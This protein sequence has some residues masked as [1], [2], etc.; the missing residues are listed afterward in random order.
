MTTW[1]LAAMLGMVIV[2]CLAGSALSRKQAA[3][4]CGFLLVCSVLMILLVPSQ[5]SAS[6]FLAGYETLYLD[7]LSLWL[8]PYT[9]LIYLAIFLCAPRAQISPS[10]TS[11]MML[12]LAAD[13]CCFSTRQPF[14][15]ALFWTLS[16]LGLLAE[17]RQS[18]RQNQRLWRILVTYLG[19]S[20]LLFCLGVWADGAQQP[21][22]LVAITLSI[23]MRKAMIP[24]HHWLPE[25]FAK[26][27]LGHVIALC[28]PQVG[29]YATVRLLAGRASPELLVALGAFSLI[30]A[31][32]GAC[33]AIGQR[34]FRG[35]YAGLFMGQTSLVFAGLQ[36]TTLPAL[37]GGLVVWLSGG[38][39]L[40]GLG[41][42]VWAL[43]ARRGKMDLGTFH[44]GYE[45]S[46]ILA[47]SFLIFGLASCGFPGT[48]GFLGQDLLLQGTT[49]EYPHIGVLTAIVTGLNSITIVRTYFRLFCGSPRTYATSQSL[50]LRERGALLLLLLFVLGLGLAPIALLNSRWVVGRRILDTR[51]SVQTHEAQRFLRNP[52]IK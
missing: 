36:C 49:Q 22:A 18:P 3:E 42:C 51:H 34:S 9:L 40:T 6:L 38:L 15:M 1:I 35:V 43:L 26:G 52:V 48:L 29:A 2:A 50:R 19:S 47:N 21:W 11:T 46:P 23:A 24:F 45:R 4:L 39:S 33:L 37:V 27:P 44:G 32:H 14:L 13:L 5:T 41:L 10:W 30:T 7:E 12:S 17:M 31:L 20:S 8:L 16:P 28:S 25:L